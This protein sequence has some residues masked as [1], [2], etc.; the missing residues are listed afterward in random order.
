MNPSRNKIAAKLNL[1]QKSIG[2]MQKGGTNTAQGYKFLSDAQIMEK[3]NGLF[4][5][6]KILFV[7]GSRI[8]GTQPTPSQKQTLTDVLVDYEFLDT[9][10]GE[11]I[12]GQAAGQGTDPGDK[13]VYKAITGAI[14]YIFMKTFLIP[15]GDDPEN[16]SKE[17][18][19]GRKTTKV[20]HINPDKPPFGEGADENENPD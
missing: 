14:K 19:S 8:V 11:S 7:Y 2:Y 4:Q 15:T 6:N 3:F 18:S 20:I 1:I 12:K 16:D 10:S 9:E 17:P 5:E 13:G